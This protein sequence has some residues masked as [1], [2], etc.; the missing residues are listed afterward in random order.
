M[1]THVFRGCTVSVRLLPYHFE[2]CRSTSHTMMTMA[3]AVMIV[4]VNMVVL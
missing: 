1:H 2:E 3:M 4:M